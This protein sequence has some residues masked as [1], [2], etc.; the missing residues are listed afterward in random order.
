MSKARENILARI[1]SA[2]E[3][4]TEKPFPNV[5]ISSPIYAEEP[6]DIAITFAESLIDVGGK[7]IYCD[8]PIEFVNGLKRLTE[9]KKWR[10]VYCWDADLQGFLSKADY[11]QCR[12][13]KNLTRADVGITSCEALIARTGSVL[14][15][16]GQ[17]AGRSL[18]IYPPVHIIV[19]TLDQIV[20]DIKDGIK[21]LQETYGSDL[22][23]MAC[24]T[25][26]P[27]RTADIEK[28][29]VLGA[30]GP[31]ELYVFVLE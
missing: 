26:G 2:L 18:S 16:S 7:F 29:L 19:A 5:N 21:V 10:H 25:T 14:L 6:E 22:P 30:H 1:K 4:K 24:F 28:T 17:A 15:S 13:G 11:R 23:S 8:T 9:A 3:N 27:S 12:I 20:Y 31:R